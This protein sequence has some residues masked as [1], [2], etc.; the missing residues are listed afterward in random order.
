MLKTNRFKIFTFAAIFSLIVPFGLAHSEDLETLELEVIYSNGDRRDAFKTSYIVYQDYSTTPF[1]EKTNFESIPEDILLP[2]GHRY[3][4]EIFVD[5]T[6]SETGFITL[7]DK[8]EKLDV[9]I[10]LP[11]GVKFNVFY[12]DGETPLGEANIK[13]KTKN[14]EELSIGNTN[15]NG[16]TLRYW[17]QP[18][19]LEDDYYVADIFI[20]RRP[21]CK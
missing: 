8:S 2:T 9:I 11:G 17:L 3:K 13:L 12:E 14:G 19:I 20:V 21:V 10:P 7:E 16:D 1:L 5:G 6:Y 4:V 18:T 15:E